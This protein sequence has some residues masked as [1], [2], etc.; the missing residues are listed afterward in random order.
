MIAADAKK[1]I[2]QS[3]AEKLSDEYAHY[4]REVR[5]FTIHSMA[6]HRRVSCAFL[7]HL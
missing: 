6:N 3:V 4:L 7:E 5:G 2:T 1:T